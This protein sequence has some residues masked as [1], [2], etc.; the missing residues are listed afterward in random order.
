MKHDPP[1]LERKLL[2]LLTA[3]REDGD[4][5]ARAELNDRLRADPSARATMAR[6]LVDEQALVDRLRQD[7]IVALLDPPARPRV[8]SLSRRSRSPRFARVAMA[9][10][11]ALAGFFVWNQLAGTGE[12]RRVAEHPPE[13]VAVIRETAG[14]V[15]RD[16]EA[17]PGTALLP[18]PLR[19]ASGMVSI[20][21]A[22][23]ARVLL[24]GPAELELRT[25]MEAFCR[26][27]KMRVEVPPPARG[28]AVEI[29]A[30]RVVD[31]GTTFGL[32]V[33]DDG[34]A[35]V[36]VIRGE[37]EVRREKAIHRLTREAAVAID[38][39][40]TITAAKIPESAFPDERDF[41]QRVI[42]GD[43]LGMKRWELSS[44]L[45][46]RDP[47]TLLCYTFQSG[48]GEGGFMRNLAGAPAA[49]SHGSP[50]G[51]SWTRGRWPGKRALE[52]SGRS[53]RLLF[54]LDRKA[55]AATYLAWVRFDSLANPYNILLMPDWRRE[56]GLQWMVTGRGELRLALS[57]GKGDPSRISG[58][59]GPVIS[60]AVS[61]LDFGRWIFLASTYD[62]ATGRVVH[63]RD[64][65]RIGEG[66]FPSRLPVDFGSYS[67]G[68]WHF[69]AGGTSG[70][71]SD[72][73]YRNFN[74]R[75][76]ELAI[77]SRALSAD[78]ISRLHEEGKP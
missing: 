59:E 19:L 50:V 31:I 44:S 5:N 40:G 25:E 33:R 65:R 71:R 7:G 10:A 37:I 13:P 23:G 9:A 17:T 43:R 28:F 53:D 42:A 75:L 72:D 63:Y 58:W 3:F 76:D 47:A 57:N 74:G 20:E 48:E 8:T 56:L 78:E 18:G 51:T 35:S 54:Q 1:S 36:K 21:F 38:P 14:A 67:F 39:A 16:A 26:S 55:S 45:V 73:R 12:S 52:F 41:R 27:G 46:S 22:S 4:R 24:E 30:A 66:S 64:G 34:A 11:V 69:G 70:R 68:N 6:L 49:G 15:W 62:A 77:L 32:D 2:E 60:P 61:N 29:P